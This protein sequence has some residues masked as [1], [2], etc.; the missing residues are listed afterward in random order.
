[1]S[2]IMIKT[3]VYGILRFVFSYLGVQ[4]TWWGIAI[5]V[6]G[7]CSAVLGVAYAFVETNIKRLLAY[8]SIENIGI[9]FMGIG[10]GFIAFARGNAAVCAL[11]VTASLLHTFNHSLFKGSLFLSAGSIHYATHT[12]NMEE[13]GGLI[14]RMPVT[15]IFLLGG[16]LAGSALVPFNG[17]AGEWLTYQSLFANILPGQ[18]GINIL[19]VLAVAALALAGALA[20]ACF[21]KLFGTSFLGLSRSGHASQAKEVPCTMTIGAGI[22]AALCLVTGLFP[23]LALNLVGGAVSSLTGTS[24]LGRLKNGFLIVYDP[25]EISG[26]LISPLSALAVMAAVILL[27]LIVIRMIGGK[28]IERKY[29]TWDCGFEA[30]N[31]RM[32]YSATGYSKPLKIVFRILYR[33]SRK[34]TVIGDLRYHPESIEYI[35]SSESIFEQYLY[36]PFCERIKSF[37]L[38]VK[39][40]IQ[41][42]NIHNYLLYIFAAILILMAYN[43]LF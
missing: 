24:I 17:F 33:P 30:I 11:A 4:S 25:L 40:R 8:S 7:I 28:Y 27:S 41:T 36:K 13:L 43:R 1:M 14:K 35:T 38:W 31:A 23:R 2:G 29:G 39:F 37:S 32:Q 42:G 21:V 3:A 26:N 5:L 19:S 9:I 18:A 20:V 10:I 15:S 22:L 16:A 34:I 6:I 12:K